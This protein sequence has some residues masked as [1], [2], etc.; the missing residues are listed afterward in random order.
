LPSSAIKHFEVTEEMIENPSGYLERLK[1]QNA[2][3]LEGVLRNDIKRFSI[4]FE[5]QHGFK[6]EFKAFAQKAL[7]EEATESGRSIQSLCSEKFKDFEHGLS[8]IHR[9]TGQ[10]EILTENCPNG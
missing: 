5:N 8:I 4:S 10:T 9:N 6:L 1:E 3:L 2:H 7:M